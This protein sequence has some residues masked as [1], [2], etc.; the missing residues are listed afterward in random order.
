MKKLL[1]SLFFFP[2]FTFAQ[3][4]A[5]RP[6]VTLVNFTLVND[7]DMPYPNTEIKLVQYDNKYYST[8]T[9]AEGKNS[10]LLD[11]S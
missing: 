3:D 1:L 6:G 7:F 9:N 5:P 2:F 4:L 11:R 8:I 10:I